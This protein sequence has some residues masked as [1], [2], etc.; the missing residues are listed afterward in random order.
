MHSKKNF[1]EKDSAEIVTVGKINL[2]VLLHKWRD[3]S[4]SHKA[5]HFSCQVDLNI[6]S[7]LTSTVYQTELRHAVEGAASSHSQF[8]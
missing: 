8:N 5:E 6:C 1:H 3:P 2:E 7:F 4:L